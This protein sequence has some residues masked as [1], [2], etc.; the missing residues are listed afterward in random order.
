MVDG[1]H[2]PGDHTFCSGPKGTK[3]K[4]GEGYGDDDDTGDD[5]DMRMMMMRKI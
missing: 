5:E 2:C 4:E 3:G 1:V